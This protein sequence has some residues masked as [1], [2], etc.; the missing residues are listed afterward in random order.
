MDGE[1]GQVGSWGGF[2]MESTLGK[3]RGGKKHKE[4]NGESMGRVNKKAD[5]NKIIKNSC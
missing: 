4:K 2:R 1:L 3:G 5:C